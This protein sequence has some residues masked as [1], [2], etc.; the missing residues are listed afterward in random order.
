MKTKKSSLKRRNTDEEVQFQR[1]DEEI[2]IEEETVRVNPC[3]ILNEVT[4][5]HCGVLILAVIGAVGVGCVQPLNGLIMAHAMNGLNSMYETI[6]YDKG[7]K[8]AMIF[9]VM[10]FLQGIFNFFNDL[11]VY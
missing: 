1:R 8:F 3:R 7:L 4:R 11:D 2:Y 6:R 5:D 10:A 9:L